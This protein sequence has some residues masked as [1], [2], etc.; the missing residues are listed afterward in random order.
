MVKKL[1]AVFSQPKSI[2]CHF[3]N[4]IENWRYIVKFENCIWLSSYK[5]YYYIVRGVGD[6]FENQKS[7][8]VWELSHTKRNSIKTIIEENIYKSSNTLECWGM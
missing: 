7:Q 5:Y 6:L 4:S 1:D 3:I 8:K 2:D